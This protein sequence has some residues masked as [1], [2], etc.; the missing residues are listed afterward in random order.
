LARQ[1]DLQRSQMNHI[2]KNVL[3]EGA[4]EQVQ[5]GDKQVL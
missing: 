4:F 3:V 2:G 5:L 1:K